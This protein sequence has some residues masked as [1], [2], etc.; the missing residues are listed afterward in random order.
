MTNDQKKDQ[1][2]TA[3]ATAAVPETAGVDLETAEAMEGIA[4]GYMPELYVERRAFSWKGAKKYAYEVRATI[5][6]A[7]VKIELAPKDLGGYKLIEIVFG[8]EKKL[9]LEI[10]NAPYKDDFGRTKTNFAYSV[11]STDGIIACPLWPKVKSDGTA[12]EML[13]SQEV[14]LRKVAENGGKL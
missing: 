10:A 3:A 1:T 14:Y 5:R 8:S 4:P 11:R 12:L 2:K 13:I 6:G 9:K 7:D